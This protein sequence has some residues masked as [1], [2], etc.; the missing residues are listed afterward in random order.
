M[1]RADKPRESVFPDTKPAAGLLSRQSL[2][3]SALDGFASQDLANLMPAE[4]HAGEYWP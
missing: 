2:Y 4:P 1:A 3:A